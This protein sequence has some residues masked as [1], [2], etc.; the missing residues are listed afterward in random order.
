[1]I[2]PRSCDCCRRPLGDDI[3]QFERTEGEVVFLSHQRWTI[4]PRTAGLRLFNICPDCGDYLARAIQHLREAL[5]L[6][7]ARPA[8]PERERRAG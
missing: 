1:M 7:T 4:E 8:E 3:V 6:E 2:R 5:G